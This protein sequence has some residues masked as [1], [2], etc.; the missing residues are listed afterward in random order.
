MEINDINSFIKYHA[1]IKNR[2]ARLF[3]FIPKD[4][5][6][7]TYSPG[8]FTFGDLIRHLA[9]TER[10]MYTENARS[11]PSLYRG[12]DESFA[13]GYGQTI[14][15]YN[16]LNKESVQILS[17]L[18]KSDLNKKC[19]TPAGAEI[20]VWKLLRAMVEH[21]VHHRAVIYTYL[22]MLKIKTPAIFGLTEE[23]VRSKGKEM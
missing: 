12:C 10:Y 23:E 18:T 17:R 1:R 13:K 5:I 6:E 20:T 2:T 9:L 19:L 3:D 16:R 7:W 22:G 21:E 14:E 8:K 4:K 11:K 15:L